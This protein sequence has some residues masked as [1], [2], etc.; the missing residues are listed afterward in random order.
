MHSWENM[1]PI[2]HELSKKQKNK[3]IIGVETKTFLKKFLEDPLRENIILNNNIFLLHLGRPK[4]ISEILRLIFF[5]FKLI[6]SK[7]DFIFETIDFDKDLKLSKFFLNFNLL[8]GCKR[9]KVFCDSLTI[10]EL[11]NTE[12]FYDVM[13]IR[14]SKLNFEKY[15][16]TLVSNDIKILK[17][18]YKDQISFP[19]KNINLGKIKFNTSWINYINDFYDQKKNKEE[20]DILVPLTATR[21]KFLRGSQATEQE[22]KMKI[23]FE[24]LSKIS[25]I[26][27]VFKPHSKSDMNYFYEEISNFNL[28][29]KV[30]YKHLY[31]LIQKSKLVLTYHPT[32]AQ[33]FV[34]YFKKPV[35]EYGEYDEEIEKKLNGKAR[36]FE[37]VDKRIKFDKFELQETISDYLENKLDFK[38]KEFD[39]NE[40]LSNLFNLIK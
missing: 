21:G 22:V 7:F 29:Y 20:F 3:I 39:K 36:Y 15:D 16:Y 28:N 18:V 23:I 2:V 8:L 32:S 25:N 35:I 26:K 12:I 31:Y 10:N 6:F 11:K 9:I 1:L 30:S 40:N 27:V 37:S 33:I 14:H 38:V 34:K 4:N 5:Y 17:N 19:K 13:N 24:I